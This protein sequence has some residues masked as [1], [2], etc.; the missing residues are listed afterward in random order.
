MHGRNC[1]AMMSGMRLQFFTNQVFPLFPLFT[2]LQ[3]TNELQAEL[4]EWRGRLCLLDTSA[5][6][7]RL[8]LLCDE[9]DAACSVLGPAAPGNVSAVVEEY[10]FPVETA[11]A[12]RSSEMH[13][14]DPISQ[15]LTSEGKRGAETLHQVY[16]A[17]IEQYDRIRKDMAALVDTSIVQGEDLL[18]RFAVD[19]TTATSVTAYAPPV[20][21][22]SSACLS[23]EDPSSCYSVTC[24]RCKPW[25]WSAKH[26]GHL[27]WRPR[28]RESTNFVTSQHLD[29][30]HVVKKVDD[31]NA[32]YEK[33]RRGRVAPILMLSDPN[34]RARVAAAKAK[35]C[36]VFF[37]FVV[38]L[39][40]E[41]GGG[42]EATMDCLRCANLQRFRWIPMD[43]AL[44]PCYRA[45]R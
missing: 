21:C 20:Q 28:V 26:R 17:V 33:Q 36:N 43:H 14:L 18:K 13:L 9:V 41:T 25:W 12:L 32:M 24:T 11:I 45:P 39:S 4:S 6:Q 38:W 34:L 31:Y 44:R 8:A 23:Q 5:L 19:Q 37:V 2:V 16:A 22:Y 27:A 10:V 29:L 42:Q 15:S 40:V 30:S 3:M 7:S 35:V 1:Q